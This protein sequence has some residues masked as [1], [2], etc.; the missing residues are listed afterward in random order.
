MV[1]FPVAK[2]LV[3]VYICSIYLF[4]FKRSWTLWF[5]LILIRRRQLIRFIDKPDPKIVHRNYNTYNYGQSDWDID[6]HRTL[7]GWIGASIWLHHSN[8]RMYPV[9]L[10]HRHEPKRNSTRL[11]WDIDPSL[12]DSTQLKRAQP[13]SLPPLST[14]EPPPPL[15]ANPNH[16]QP[17][18]EE[19]PV[20]RAM[21]DVI[22]SGWRILRR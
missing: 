8:S 6:K 1:C 20:R 21:A 14:I 18:V 7:D 3:I 12:H 10:G 22:P 15:A 5:R 11:D 19:T 13:P 4:S 9:G 17:V 16:R 2:W